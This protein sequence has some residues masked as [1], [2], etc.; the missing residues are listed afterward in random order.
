MGTLRFHGNRRR[1]RAGNSNV[2]S[3]K[4]NRIDVDGPSYATGQRAALHFWL[5]LCEQGVKRLSLPALQK[6]LG[7][8]TSGAPLHRRTDRTE[9]TQAFGGVLIRKAPQA[10]QKLPAVL[11]FC[12]TRSNERES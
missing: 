11:P 9:H 5:Q 10:I 4:L 8:V 3:E 6:Y 12:G 7:P 2:R 1:R